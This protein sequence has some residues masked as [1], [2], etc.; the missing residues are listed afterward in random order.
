MPPFKTVN[1]NH[2]DLL[3]QAGM[4]SKLSLAGGLS[5]RLAYDRPALK[6][7]IKKIIFRLAII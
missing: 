5:N 2:Y 4:L 1:R 3:C 6:Q 7:H